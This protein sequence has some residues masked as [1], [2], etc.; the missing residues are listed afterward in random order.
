M[1]LL[2]IFLSATL[3]MVAFSFSGCQPNNSDTPETNTTNPDINNTLPPIDVNSTKNPVSLQFI[4]SNDINVTSSGEQRAV[5]IR[6]FDASGTLNTEGSI[7][8]QYPGKP[9]A[10]Q[11]S[12]NTATIVDGIAQFTYTAPLDLQGRVNAGDS[13]SDY[14]FFSTSNGA[15]N[16][17]LHVNYTPGSTIVVGDPILSQLTLSESTINITQ[18]E[19]TKTLTL[20]AYT[21]QS[22]TDINLEVGIQYGNLGLDVGYFTPGSPSIVN[23]RV[24]FEYH[25]PLNLLNTSNTLG[26]TA[27]TLFD[28]ANP[29]VTAPLVVNFIPGIPVIRVENPTVSLTRNTQTETITVLAFDSLSNKAFSTGTILVEY[30]TDITNGTVSGGTFTQN[31]ATIVNG[32]AVFTFNGPNP[33]ASIANQ[34]FV[35]K[36]KENQTVATNLVMQ[37]TPDLPQISSLAI[38]E[39]TTILTQN[40]QTHTVVINALDAAGSF[41]N[42]GTINVKFPA[43]ISAGTDLGTFTSFSVDIVNGQATFSY[44]GPVDLVKTSG[45]TASETFTFTDAANNANTVNWI[46]NFTPDTP[47]LRVESPTVILTGDAQAE[48]VT[49]LAFDSNNQAFNTGTILVEY[50]TDITNGTVSGGTFTQNEATI[51]NGKAVFTFN[52][53]NPLASIAN[54]TFV[55]KYKE[56]QTVATNLVMQYTPDL[57]QISSLAINKQVTTFTQNSQLYTVVINALD[58][59]GDFVSSGIINV[60]FPAAISNGTDVGSFTE[61][62]VNVVNGQATFSYTGP[63]DL[64]ATNAITA[65]EIFT[66]VDASNNTNTVNWTTNFTPDTPTLRV[67]S[68]TIILISDAQS[69]TVTVLAFDSNNQAFNTGTVLV[70]YPTD[71]TSGAVSGGTFTQNEATIING[72]AVFE[73]SGPAKLLAIATQVF[74]FKYKSNPISVATLNIE[75]TPPTIEVILPTNTVVLKKNSEVI[76]IDV[77]VVDSTNNNPYS[78]GEVKVQFPSDIK[79]GRDIG[80]FSDLNVSIVGGHALFSYTAPTVLDANESNITFAFYHDTDLAPRQQFTFIIEPDTNQEVLTSYQLSSSIDT[81][82]STMDIDSSKS[83]SFFIKDEFGGDVADQNITSFKV[84]ILNPLLGTLSS[85][86]GNETNSTSNFLLFTTSSVSMNVNSTTISGVIPLKIDVEFFD[87]NN[88]A[89][90]LSKVF[91]MVVLSGPPSAI[92]LSYIGTNIRETPYQT[93]TFTENWMLRVT[94]RYDNVVNSNPSVSV[95]MIAGYT[96]DATNSGVGANNY[97]YFENGG[98]MKKISQTFETVSNVFPSNIDS[99]DSLVVFGDGFTYEASGKWS[100]TDNSASV[101]D[102]LETFDGNDS[103]STDLGFAV[104]NNHRQDPEGGEAVVTVKPRDANSIMDDTGS[105]VIEVEYDYFL[106]GKSVMLWANLVGFDLPTGKTTRIG[107]A[108]KVTLRALGLSAPIE[109][110]AAGET[111]VIHRIAVEIKD[112]P[113]YYRHANFVYS[114]KT[115]SNLQVNSVTS[116]NNNLGNNIAYVDVNVTDIDTVGAAGTIEITNIRVSSEF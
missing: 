99:T 47:T 44:T 38:N 89:Q 48:T 54:Q 103:L 116:S 85:T 102:L 12:P 67:E 87:V 101:L 10:G 39:A 97:L 64:V 42:S 46:T 32:K 50:P 91:N 26:T 72:K 88:K 15:V 113:A 112:S 104:G 79:T 1:N 36:Y 76:T 16:I 70:E 40:A 80:F 34:T 105:M 75:Y 14:T 49:V 11:F 108:K 66:F 109:N 28:K 86:D 74:T 20:F 35:F 73:F 55:F 7:T 51:V 90:I 81:S 56:N 69:E 111:G 115:S 13:F 52:G 25:G 23:G 110:T 30:P 45:I 60:K 98:S 68:S 94:D 19:E 43:A 83:V 62:S 17:T 114:V 24:T 41:V 58:S 59:N 27:F 92:S 33:L 93:A 2:K 53:P 63:V 100:F 4:F 107:E 9:D 57:P 65:S 77:S 61:I 95:G 5:Y 31:E 84:T 106:T 37:Y 6:A 22:T 96:V 3:L 82:G 8:V 71:I 78:E 21:D 29:G 18:S